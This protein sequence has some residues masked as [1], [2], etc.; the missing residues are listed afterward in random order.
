MPAHALARSPA[1]L[2]PWRL[3][4]LRLAYLIMAV[5]LGSFMIPKLSGAT[6]QFVAA[7]GIK[8]A[9]L[10]GFAALAALGLRYPLQM[11][12]LMLL[13]FVFKITYLTAYYWPIQ[14][15]GRVTPEIWRDAGA[16]MMAVIFIPLLPWD[17]IVRHYVLRRGDPWW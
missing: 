9:M 13:E 12:P 17:Y 11:L 5:G 4:L 15:A 6:D 16:C 7:N 1:E 3:N 2:A 8:T 14:A 10:V